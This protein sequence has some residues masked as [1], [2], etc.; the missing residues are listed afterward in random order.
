MIRTALSQ[1]SDA[2]TPSPD[3]PGF[4]IYLHWPFCMAKCPYCDFNS[5]VRHQPVDQN[6]FANAM[7]AELRHYKQ[8][9]DATQ[10]SQP[11]TSIFFG[12]GTPSLM[13]PDIVGRL[14]DE[15]ASLWPVAGEAEITLEANPTSVEA[16]NFKGYATAGVNRVS[17]GVQSLRDDQ[18]KFLGRL[19]SADEARAAITL[20]Q[21]HFPRMSFDLIYARPHQTLADWANELDEAVAL[22]ADHLSLYQLTIEQDTPFFALYRNGKF[23]LPDEDASV[24]LY[25]QTHDVLEKHGMP[26]YEISNHAKPGHESRHNLT[27]WR[28]GD[29]LG[30]GAGAHGRLTLAN[31]RIAT[32]NERHPEK[33]L[34]KVEAEETGA[35]SEDFLTLDEQS[36]EF[37]IMGLRV[38][39][40][41][42][43]E[44]FTDLA[45]RS[46]DL[47]QIDELIRHGLIERVGNNRI[48]AT[49]D[50]F[51][52]LNSLVA[53]LAS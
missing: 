37:L 21:K 51:L 33:W 20:A 35:I 43:L 39:E 52:V 41:I 25:E 32:A 30:V 46:L 48:R 1:D 29:Y 28:Y 40:G 2:N 49:R 17:L 10:T 14:L 42:N 7:I 31:G 22:A 13:E 44:R 6:R 47:S 23:E 8:R 15:I 5:H 24:A 4:G 11:V 12:G 19:H 27:Y 36:D 53:E 26:A 34:E 38:K 45:G 18:L 3:H 16:E 9:L 50:G